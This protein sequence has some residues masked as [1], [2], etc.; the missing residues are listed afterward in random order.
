MRKRAGNRE[1]EKEGEW[2]RKRE[3]GRK[4]GIHTTTLENISSIPLYEF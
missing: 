2:G 4:R 1:R 3:K